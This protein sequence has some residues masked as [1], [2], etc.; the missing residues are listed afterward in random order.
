MLRERIDPELIAGLD[1]AAAQLPAARP[2]GAAAGGLLHP[3]RRH[4]RDRGRDRPLALRRRRLRRGLG[5]IPAGAGEPAPGAGRGLLRG[6]RL[7]RGQRRAAGD[8]PG[9]DRRLRR[10][11]RRRPGGGDGD[12][13]SRPSWPEARLPDTALPA[14]R[15][16]LLDTVVPGDRRHRRL[17]RL[18]QRGGLAGAARRALGD[19]RG[20][21]RGAAGP[22]R[23]PPRLPP[24]VPRL[25]V[26]GPSARSQHW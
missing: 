16:P 2:R 23:R 22:R 13:R 5:R 10:Q 7:D 18:G 3:R 1:A 14:A 21:S 6:P 26:A 11:R 19:R 9:A 20:W 8:R 17:R 12:R 4:D 15:R 25:G 24:R